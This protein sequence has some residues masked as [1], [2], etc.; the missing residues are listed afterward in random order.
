MGVISMVQEGS[1]TTGDFPLGWHRI[2]HSEV[3]HHGF[4]FN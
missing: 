1:P 2:S 4:Q 3:F